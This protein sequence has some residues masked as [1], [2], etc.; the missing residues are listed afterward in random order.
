MD[1]LHNNY[2][3]SEGHGPTFC[4]EIDPPSR[5]VKSYFEETV[6]ACEMIWSQKEGP[7][8]LCLSG[9]LD[10]EYVFSVLLKLGMKVEPVIMRTK[11]NSPEIKFAYKFCYEH[12]IEPTVIDLDFDQF[13]ASDQ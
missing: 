9:G 1:L 10:S 5:P 2:M 11:Y 7:L 3:R 12:N 8:Q 6:T 13:I 4:V